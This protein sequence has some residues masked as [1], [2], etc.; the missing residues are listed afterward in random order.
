MGVC[1]ASDEI[2]DC[3]CRG[4]RASSDLARVTAERDEL[5]RNAGDVRAE[6]L[7]A[8][9]AVA[10]M[11]ANPGE[12][13]AE[14]VRRVGAERDALRAEVEAMRAVVEAARP[15]ASGDG[16]PSVMRSRLAVQLTA[17]DALRGKVGG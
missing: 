14:A 4:C 6:I 8:I 11:T 12:K 9:E 3:L 15:V 10:N 1:V 13:Y 5:R 2:H 16:H 7:D 17:L